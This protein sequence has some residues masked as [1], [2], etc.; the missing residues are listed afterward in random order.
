MAGEF[1]AMAFF[2]LVIPAFSSKAQFLNPLWGLLFPTVL[3]IGQ[4]WPV[5]LADGLPVGATF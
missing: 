5:C 4:K 3:P 1:M 2:R